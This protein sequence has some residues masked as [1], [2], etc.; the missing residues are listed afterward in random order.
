[1]N[2]AK[3]FHLD[4]VNSDIM[5]CVSNTILY[6]LQNPDVYGVSVVGAETHEGF[7]FTEI[8]VS[9]LDKENQNKILNA[10]R[11]CATFIRREVANNVALKRTP[12]IR[13][14]IDKGQNNYSRVDE[15][16]NQ[17]KKSSAGE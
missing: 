6:K 12:E 14:S 5:R 7:A 1:M 4:R 3:G 2:K 9:V 10:L 17:I 16:L 15:L 13:F 8:F 11:N